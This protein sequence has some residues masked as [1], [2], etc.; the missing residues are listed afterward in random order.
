M[1]VVFGQVQIA[2]MGL[3]LFQKSPTECGVSE[4][5]NESST[6]KRSWPTGG[7]CVMGK[8]KIIYIPPPPDSKFLKPF[9]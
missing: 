6:M 8:K 7:C 1:S 2:A 4:C 5:D 3:S 9:L